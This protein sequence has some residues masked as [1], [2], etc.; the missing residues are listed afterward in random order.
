MEKIGCVAYGVEKGAQGGPF[1]GSDWG[2]RT[3]NF[4]QS[5]KFSLFNR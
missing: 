1:G 2:L 4:G 5:I 3:E